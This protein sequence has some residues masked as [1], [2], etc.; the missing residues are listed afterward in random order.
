MTPCQASGFRG[1]GG[2]SDSTLGIACSRRWRRHDSSKR[3]QLLPQRYSVTSQKVRI[4]N[5]TAV[6]RPHPSPSRSLCIHIQT[7]PPCGYFWR[8][9]RHVHGVDHLTLAKNEWSYT[10]SPP[11]CLGSMYGT[12]LFFTHRLWLSSHLFWLC[13]TS[14]AETEMLKCVLQNVK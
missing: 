8:V 3:R 4:L 12:N 1:F 5:S 6:S 7:Q 13:I 10:S 14:M 11:V 9:K 2:S